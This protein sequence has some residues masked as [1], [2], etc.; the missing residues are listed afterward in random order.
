MRSTQGGLAWLHLVPFLALSARQ[1]EDMFLPHKLLS[2]ALGL[3]CVLQVEA[4]PPI[5]I[6]SSLRLIGHF[7]R[8]VK[9]Y[10]GLDIAASHAILVAMRLSIRGDVVISYHISFC[11]QPWA[12]NVLL[13]WK[14]GSQRIICYHIIFCDQP[15][16]GI[17]LLRWKQVLTLH[18]TAV[19]HVILGW[20]CLVI[21]GCVGTIKA[22][23]LRLVLGMLPLRW[24]QDHTLHFK[25][26]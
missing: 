7:K 11:P 12:W 15:W 26:H 13:G 19:S 3:E 20:E 18:K 17:V 22:S 6:H 1:S 4:R 9:H 23:D 10:R 2:P 25:A 5:A 24:K 14:P 16:A 21:R 8:I